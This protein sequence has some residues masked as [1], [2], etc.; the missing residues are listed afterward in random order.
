[1]ARVRLEPGDWRRGRIRACANRF[2]DLAP[3]GRGAFSLVELLVVLAS[4]ALLLAL[5]LPALGRA[6][7][8]V[9]AVRC[10]ANLRNVAFAFQLFV[11]G[12]TP[13][14][15]GDSEQLGRNYLYI[16]DFQDYAYRID[17]FWDGGSLATV[18]LRPGR[19]LMLCATAPSSLARHPGYPCSSAALDP[20]EHVNFAANMRLYRGLVSYMQHWFL[21]PAAATHVRSDIVQHP[22]VPLVMD[23]DAEAAVRR[24]VDPFYIAPP[25]PGQL[26]PYANGRYWS[27][28]LRHAGA[29]N[30]A[31]VGGHVLSSR[32]PEQESWD[33]TYQADVGTG[34]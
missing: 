20:L 28:G 33:W 2:R 3:A 24:G 10:S 31:F 34:P 19:D 17:E 23:V 16:N 26:G 1:M 25:V 4:I 6:R 8:S 13:N 22:Y 18:P 29:A 5:L 30:V 15:K 12:H 7:D 14:G 27:I 11:D 9:K 32:R 21:S